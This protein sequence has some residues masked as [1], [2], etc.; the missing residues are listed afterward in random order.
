M[1]SETQE[2]FAR[3]LAA[4]GLGSLAGSLEP[5]FEMLAGAFRR[6]GKLLVCGNGGSAADSEHIVGELMKE[7]RIRRPLPE[8]QVSLLAGMWGEEG[9]LLGRRLQGALPA[10]S[11]V[12]QVSL[13]T[14]MANDAGADL[15]FAQQVYAY[16]RPGDAFLGI[17]TSGN[18]ANVVAACLAARALGLRTLALTGQ[19][20][21]RLKEVCELAL[22]A[23][24]SSTSEIQLWHMRCYHLLCAMLELE[25]FGSPGQGG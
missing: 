7:F 24:A 20:G 9:R 8:E 22:L 17:S 23:P 19:D 21:G 10:I 4:S 3:E 16:G 5:A 6:G 11:L 12:S 18:A 14:A 13:G 2:Y 1:K 15:V 25:I